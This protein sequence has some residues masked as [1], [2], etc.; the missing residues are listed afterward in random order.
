MSRSIDWCFKIFRQTCIGQTLGMG[1]GN[2]VRHMQ[3]LSYTYDTY[4]ICMGL[5]P[6]ISS[7]IA[8]NVQRIAVRHMQVCL[9]ILKYHMI[10]DRMYLIN[11]CTSLLT[12]RTITDSSYSA[13]LLPTGV[14]Y[15]SH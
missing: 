12:C 15:C 5:G 2:W 9:Y 11:F 7:V 14:R 10:I 6:S 8:K 3:S 13:F 1:P 4:L